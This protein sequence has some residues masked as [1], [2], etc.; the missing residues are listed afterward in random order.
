MNKLQWNTIDY[1]SL[2]TDPN[3][4]VKIGEE[5]ERMSWLKSPF[6]SFAGT[7][8]DRGVR[9]FSVKNDQPYRP[10]L[11][12]KLQGEGVVGNAD[13]ETNYDSMEILSQTIYPLVV[14]N[15]LR[16]QIHQ[17]STMRHIDFVKEATDSLAEW[18]QDKRDKA[19]VCA[20]CNDFTN[21]VI[22][23]QANGFKD[24]KGKR[25]IANET[26]TIAAGDT[27]NVK[28][29][30]R[31]I[32]M[33]RSGIGFG[34]GDAFPIKPIKSSTIG[35]AGLSIFYNSYL[36][37]LDSYQANQLKADPEWKEMQAHAGERG[38]KN[39]LFTG[40]LGMVDNCPVLDMGVYTPLQVGMLNSDITDDEFKKN[41]NPLNFS[42]ITPPSA[43]AG[44]QSVSFGALIGASALIMAGSDKVNFYVDDTEDAGRKVVCGV[45]R[46][47]S[48][49]KGRFDVESGSLSPFSKQDFA[50][51]GLFSSKE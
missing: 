4:S 34:G 15:A 46:L 29:L 1:N 20:L 14:A 35:E 17:Y 41:L 10:R 7:G 16:S 28:A 44:S 23:D 45:D 40:F 12:A 8:S 22:A 30:R 19:L 36:I 50:V 5:I 24:T 47:L 26:K 21:A 37:L 18:A 43:Y 32:F 51:I 31:A 25:N 6:A 33:A 2:K 3:I 9:I 27:M 11:K 48:I 42:K 49:S 39:R 38:E 13:L